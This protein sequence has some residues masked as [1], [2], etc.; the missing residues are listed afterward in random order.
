MNAD[1]IAIDSAHARRITDQIKAGVE[2]VWHLIEQAYTSRAWAVLGYTSWDDYCTREFGTSRLRLPREERT[3]VVASLRD[4]G[5]SNRAIASATGYSEPTIRRELAGASNDAPADPKP[6]TGIDGKT[7]TPPAPKPAPSSGFIT[8]DDLDALNSPEPDE[9]ELTEQIIEEHAAR[10]AP[11]PPKPRQRPLPQ[12][13]QDIAWDLRT[14]TERLANLATDERFTKN[15]QQASELARGH[16]LYVQETVA[17]V[18]AQLDQ[19]PR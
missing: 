10:P 16:L 8:A 19:Q 18:L 4:S 12:Q 14:A 6:I 15:R 5:L 17:A 11:T 9:D 7:Y 2:A 1:V 13:M 3:E